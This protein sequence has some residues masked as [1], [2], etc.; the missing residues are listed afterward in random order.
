MPGHRLTDG[1]F[2]HIRRTGKGGTRIYGDNEFDMYALVAL[3]IHAIA[4]F[5]VEDLKLQT[6]ALRVPNIQ[7]HHD[8]KAVKRFDKAT[9]ENAMS[10]VLEDA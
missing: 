4:Y 8:S 7:Y 6:V 10:S 9:F 2:F 5:A 3:D 1:Y